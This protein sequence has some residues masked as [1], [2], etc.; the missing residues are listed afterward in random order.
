MIKIEQFNNAADHVKS[1][2]EIQRIFKDVNDH[3][4]KLLKK[5]D[6]YQPLS[7]T[8]DNFNFVSYTSYID[9][10]LICLVLCKKFEKHIE[11][12][13]SLGFVLDADISDMCCDVYFDRYGLIKGRD[14]DK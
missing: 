10:E 12:V 2:K 13:T 4:E 8:I 6:N 11:A 1:L 3:Y 5:H 9:H 7:M 14:S